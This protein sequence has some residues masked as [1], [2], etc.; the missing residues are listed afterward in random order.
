[1]QLMAAV[2]EAPGYVQLRLRRYQRQVEH[3]M[4]IP[5]KSMPPAA[6]SWH[7]PALPAFS[8]MCDEAVRRCSTQHGLP[9]TLSDEVRLRAWQLC[10]LALDA[11]SAPAN[12]LPEIADAMGWPPE[13]VE[14]L[15]AVAALPKL[16][17]QTWQELRRARDQQLF[18]ALPPEAAAAD[19]MSNDALANMLADGLAQV[20]LTR[21]RARF[22]PAV[23]EAM[24][25]WLSACLLALDAQA[26]G[27]DETD[28]S[29]L[30]LAVFVQQ[31]L[32]GAV[33]IVEEVVQSEPEPAAE[34]AAKVEPQ[35]AAQPA[36]VAA[37]PVSA[38]VIAEPSPSPSTPE[39]ASVR[40]PPP[41]ISARPPRHFDAPRAASQPRSMR[42]IAIATI[43]GGLAIAAVLLLMLRSGNTP[44]ATQPMNEVKPRALE[45]KPT[46]QI[47]PPQPPVVE[48][49][50][51]LKVTK[52]TPT[53]QRSAK[54]QTSTA[55]QRPRYRNIAAAKR[56]HTAKKIDD[57]AY[58]AAIAE[59]EALRTTRIAK[60]QTALR[61]GKLSQTEYQR[62]V[63]AINKT[64]G[65][66]SH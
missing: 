41:G 6:T 64:L 31:R 46:A 23:T 45:P 35:P 38:E 63:D 43:A 54:Q 11:A 20:D 14:Q 59:L 32:P 47:A 56:A 51:S 4:A 40:Q 18:A 3:A 28:A 27:D 24:T 37:L 16:N 52:P 22:T 42:P 21:L 12:S 30:E 62:K 50:P 48:P 61:S 10:W 9:V 44:D 53:P 7:E 60:E 36:P 25:R 34:P 49:A 5:S 2:I 17:T 58:A 13:L 39:P 19:D 57:A 66:D 55:T 1:M 33:A 8:A 26:L 29:A 65:F 15:R